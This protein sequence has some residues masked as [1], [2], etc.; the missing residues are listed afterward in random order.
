[1]QMR[2]SRR[3]QTRSCAGFAV[4]AMALSVLAGCAT[5]RKVKTAPVAN[6]P[7]A[8]TR[9]PAAAPV[10][11]KPAAV[12]GPSVTRLLD[13]REGFIITEVPTMEEASR[14]DFDRAVALMKN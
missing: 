10:A 11:G 1:M 2:M 7:S 4:L 8:G 13:G 6:G 12:T 14:R 3:L 5:D 9:S